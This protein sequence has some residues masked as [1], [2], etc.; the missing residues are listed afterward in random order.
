MMVN[1]DDHTEANCKLLVMV[2]MIMAGTNLHG[3]CG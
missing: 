3:G 1:N 2:L